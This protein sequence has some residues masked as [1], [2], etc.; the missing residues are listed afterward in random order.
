MLG[1]PSTVLGYLQAVM[2]TGYMPSWH[3]CYG[4]LYLIAFGHGG[5]EG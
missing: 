3:G 1:M 4:S 5:Q 2:D